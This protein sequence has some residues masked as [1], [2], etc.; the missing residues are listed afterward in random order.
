VIEEIKWRKPSN[1]DGVPVWS[2]HGLICIGETY[3]NH[4]RINLAKG[5]LLPDPH[6]I[7]NSYRAI[8]IHQDDQLDPAAFKELIQAAVKLNQQTQK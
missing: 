7:I 5:Q 1:P 8:L 2:D 6:G 4:L 3:K